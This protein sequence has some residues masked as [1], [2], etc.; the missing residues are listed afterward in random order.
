M[1]TT[2]WKL[3]TLNEKGMNLRKY[4]FQ[5][6]LYDYNVVCDETNNSPEQIDRG[7][8]VTDVYIQPYRTVDYII[9]RAVIQPQGAEFEYTPEIVFESETDAY[10]DRIGV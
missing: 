4:D 7:R 1:Q 6:L 5:R 2:V 8:L 10:L 9:L 3:S